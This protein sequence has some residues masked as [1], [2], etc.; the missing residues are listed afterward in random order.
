MDDTNRARH[1]QSLRDHPY[2]NLSEGEYVIILVRKHWLALALPLSVGI[3]ILA[4][5]WTIQTNYAMIAAQLGLT[6]PA[7]D[8]TAL[9]LPTLA[10]SLFIMFGMFAVYFVYER[11]RFVL[12][13]ESVIQQ[14]QFSIFAKREQIVGLGS[15]EDSSYTQ[16]GIFAHIFNYGTIRLSTVG[17]EHTYVQNYV[18]NPRREISLLS[19]AVEAFKQER[20]I[21][22]E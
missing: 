5:L 14:I 7:A 4:A 15:I 22:K 2:L 6:G 11:N 10:F 20:Q 21:V 18:P 9:F 1:E 3:I 12:T 19:N 17:D 8:P 16:S 13:N